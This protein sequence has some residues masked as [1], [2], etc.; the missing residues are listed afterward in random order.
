MQWSEHRG[1]EGQMV[2]VF[3]LREKDE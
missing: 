3:M 2:A 1:G